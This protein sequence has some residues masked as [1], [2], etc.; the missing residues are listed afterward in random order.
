MCDGAGQGSLAL[1]RVG[2][3]KGNASESGSAL[4]TDA[5]FVRMGEQRKGK[6]LRS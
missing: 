3:F 4:Q 5:S 6:Q 2:T 1:L